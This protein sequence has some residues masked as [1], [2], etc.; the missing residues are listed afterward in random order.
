[1][2]STTLNGPPS[3]SE[4]PL[5]DLLKEYSSDRE[6]FNLSD[7]RPETPETPPDPDNGGTM[8]DTEGA[9]PG[10]PSVPKGVLPELTAEQ[11]RELKS[12]RE[13]TAKFLA[14]NTDR[15]FAF[16][17]AMI[18]Q[19]DDVD[20]WKAAPED[21]DDI[22]ECYLEMCQAYGWSGLPPWLNL[23]MCLLFTYGPAMKEAVKVRGINKELAARAAR[24]EAEKEIE[25]QRR[26][27]AEQQAAAM[28]QQAQPEKPAEPPRVDPPADMIETPAG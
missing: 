12:K 17:T 9:A 20:E 8:P 13:F 24:E 3:Y 25:K 27:A 15:A 1:M 26:I 22:Q 2:L 16:A 14:K 23:A 18:A 10:G 19:T 11:K 5:D 28:K 6:E 4:T 7:I 21:V